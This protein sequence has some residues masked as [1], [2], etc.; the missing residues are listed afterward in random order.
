MTH[1][2]VMVTYD[3]RTKT[4]KF[5]AD[6]RGVEVKGDMAYHRVC[7]MLFKATENKKE[8]IV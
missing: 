2:D 3:R 1:Q 4:F 8:G 7:L 6:G 5:Y